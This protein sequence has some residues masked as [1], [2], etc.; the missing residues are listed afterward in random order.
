MR[1]AGELNFVSPPTDT[2]HVRFAD[3]RVRFFDCRHVY[4]S[5]QRVLFSR[6]NLNRGEIRMRH[7]VQP[8]RGVSVV[9]LQIALLIIGVVALGVALT[10]HYATLPR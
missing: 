5:G 7:W 9:H 1:L 3:V 8:R 6:S 2:K 10:F 4:E